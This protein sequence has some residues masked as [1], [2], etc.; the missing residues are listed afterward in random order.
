MPRAASLLRAGDGEE[1]GRRWPSLIIRAPTNLHHAA[2]FPISTSYLPGSFD[3]E[4]ICRRISFFL[5]SFFFFFFCYVKLSELDDRCSWIKGE[6]ESCLV[7]NWME[8]VGCMIELVVWFLEKLFLPVSEWYIYFFLYLYSY[9]NF[10]FML[11]ILEFPSNFI[12]RM[13][14]F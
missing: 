5:V 12:C 3:L 7:V 10:I 11:L 8:E 13:M 14:N 2:V 4:E 9:M 6:G 1:R